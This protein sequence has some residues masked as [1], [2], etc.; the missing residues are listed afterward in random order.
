M[1]A[2]GANNLLKEVAY[3]YMQLTEYLLLDDFSVK[4]IK[5]IG[6]FWLS[7]LIFIVKQLFYTSFESGVFRRAFRVN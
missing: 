3:S 4:E 6:M 5:D 7:F 1:Q 2:A